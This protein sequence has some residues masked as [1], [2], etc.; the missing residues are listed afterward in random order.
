MDQFYGYGSEGQT[1]RAIRYQPARYD[2]VVSLWRTVFGR[3]GCSEATAMKR[4]HLLLAIVIISW[5]ASTANAQS[6]ADLARQE[7]QRK[8]T[9]DSKAVLTNRSGAT[10]DT[11][12]SGTVSVA[13]PPA[14]DKDKDKGKET[15]G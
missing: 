15:A 11:S 6:V 13:N 7:R 4:I 12:K 14:A 2:H 8:Q 5:I 1:H 9:K 3:P 10:P